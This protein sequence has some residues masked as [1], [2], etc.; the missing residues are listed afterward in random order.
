MMIYYNLIPNVSI[1]ILPLLVFTTLILA[2]GIGYWLSSISVKYR[3]VRFI[4]PFFIQLFMF[5]S[6]VIYPT[7]I[8]GEKYQWLL[9]LN[10]MT[11]LID[12]HRAVLLGHLPVNFGALG[13]SIVI[14]VLIF[15]SGIM[16]LKRTE[17]YFA[18]LI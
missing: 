13:I 18:D 14:S 11:G 16:Y 12:A 17:K 15:L 3:D 2:S 8:V 10:P 7:N 9:F 1:I 6:P 4:L 5:I